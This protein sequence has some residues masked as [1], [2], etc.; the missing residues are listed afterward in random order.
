MPI[1][2]ITKICL[3]SQENKIFQVEREKSKRSI[4]RDWFNN[5]KNTKMKNLIHK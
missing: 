3:N 2:L 1:N 5:K 4:T